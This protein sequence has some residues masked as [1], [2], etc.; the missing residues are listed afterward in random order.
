MAVRNKIRNYSF[1]NSKKLPLEKMTVINGVR[2]PSIPGTCYHAII[3]SLA[4]NKD[5]FCNWN[6][7]ISSTATNMRKY[8]GEKSWNSFR[9]RKGSKNYIQ[10][11]KDNVHT[12]TRTGR[13]CYG[14]RLHEMGMCIY[15][16]KD[17]VMLL[18]GGELVGTGDEYDVVFNDGRGLQKRYRGTAMTY[19]EYKRF[20]EAGFI[21]VNGKILNRSGV[22]KYR[23]TGHIITETINENRVQVSIVLS[24][25]YGQETA[26]RLSELGL[27][28]EASL[29]GEVIGTIPHSSINK[30]RMDVDVERIDI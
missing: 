22:Q 4:E 17:G 8:G 5:S 24:P 25:S 26:N 18:T 30:L 9:N 23:S 19:K 11:I 21:D 28:V 1:L 13:D 29:G 20:L 12:L 3:V 14:Y 16:F 27:I 7:I 15:Y 10:R 2:V 6:K